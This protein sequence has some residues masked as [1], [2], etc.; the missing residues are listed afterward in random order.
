M[1][2]SQKK[3]RVVLSC[4]YINMSKLFLCI[5]M[6]FLAFLFVNIIL[7]FPRISCVLIGQNPAARVVEINS[8]ACLFGFRFYS[9]LL[10]FSS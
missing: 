5:S 1:A 2:E 8:R 10:F 4:L 9:A 7:L 6:Y 3:T